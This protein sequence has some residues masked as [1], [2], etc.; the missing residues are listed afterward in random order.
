MKVNGT[1]ISMTRGDSETITV[2]CEARPFTA[3]DVLI[4]TVK[5]SVYDIAVKLQKVVKTFTE[6]GKA[7]IEILPE[8]T[9]DLSFR[10]Y[11]YDIQLTYADGTVTTIIKPSNFKIEAEVTCRD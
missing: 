9:S 8:D 4:F 10:T 1:N 2:S 6:D 5:E 3:G 11:C 7:V